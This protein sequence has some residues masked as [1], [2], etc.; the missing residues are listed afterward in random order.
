MDGTRLPIGLILLIW[1]WYLVLTITLWYCESKV[2]L[3][4]HNNLLSGERVNLSAFSPACLPFAGHSSEG[5]VGHIY[6]GFRFR[7]GVSRLMT[8]WP[9]SGWG[10][11]G[12]VYSARRLQETQVIFRP[13]NPTF[14]LWGGGLISRSSNTTLLLNFNRCCLL[15]RWGTSQL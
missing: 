1:F 13:R 4:D 8:S 9:L 5:V 7:K 15:P 10:L 3:Y 12:E 14:R 2:L 11:K 6:G